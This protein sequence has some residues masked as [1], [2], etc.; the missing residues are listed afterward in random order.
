[1]FNCSILAKLVNFKLKIEL[2]VY[3]MFEAR[4]LRALVYNDNF[5][6]PL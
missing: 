2:N 1:M 3:E 4:K 5:R 6:N